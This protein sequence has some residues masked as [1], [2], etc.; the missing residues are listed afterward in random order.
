MDKRRSAKIVSEVDAL[1]QRV[2]S[3]ESQ[4]LRSERRIV[5]LTQLLA[6][7]EHAPDNPMATVAETARTKFYE[8]S[9]F[10]KRSLVIGLGT[11]RSGTVSL[12]QLLNGQPSAS[13]DH[14]LKP[15]LPW[16]YDEARLDYRLWQLEHRDT[17][18]VGDV[19]YYYL[20]Y[21]RRIAS[22]VHDVRFVC[23][24]RN[25]AEVI[26]SM[27]AKTP[28]TNLWADHDGSEWKLDPAWDATMPSYPKMEKRD[29]LGR[30]WDEYYET[31]E[32]LSSEMPD[33]F[34]IFELE[35]TLNS[36]AGVTELLDFVGISRNEQARFVS[37]HENAGSYPQH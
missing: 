4:L 31:A 11:G 17:R 27:L 30:Y 33:R 16:I 21:V 37:V 7:I 12:A 23:M 1:V 18:L 14:E 19:A 8:R 15:L 2:E 24:R 29:A 35:S 22:K 36:E 25:R 32:D 3:I 6:H 20:P 9:G 28:E 34:R 26:D 5:D 13:V 10:Q